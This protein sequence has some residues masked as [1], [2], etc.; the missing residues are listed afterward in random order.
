VRRRTANGL[1]LSGSYTLSKTF[2]QAGV[3]QNVT[4][5]P[6]SAFDL[7]LDW[8]PADTDRRHVLNLTG[9]YDLPFGRDRGGLSR[10]TGGWYVAGIFSAT[11]GVPLS[12][13]QRAAVYGGGL[14]FT[15]CVGAVPTSSVETGVF[16]GVTGS[17]GIGTTGNPAT[18]G[19]G[20]N[21]FADPAAAYNAYRRV[22]IS[23]DST[24]S[25]GSLYGLPRTNFDLS[26]G[27]RT[28]LAHNVH[29]VFSVEAINVLNTLQ[30]SN[31]SLNL[32]S[33]TNFGVVTS[34]AGSPRVI[35]LGVRLEF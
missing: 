21:I 26:L 23:Q 22:L 14:S 18:G 35:Q 4:G 10:L 28:R 24:S 27:K 5:S 32:S 11:S 8:G 19:S 3:R 33:P 2:D 29:A 30:F 16:R 6:S 25:R 34:Q 15:N 12:V 9:V 1:T 31:G 7:D 13:C 20:I 17:N